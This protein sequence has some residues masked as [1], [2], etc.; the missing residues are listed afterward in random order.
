MKTFASIFAAMMLGLL[1]LADTQAQDFGSAAFFLNPGN[2]CRDLDDQQLL[3]GWAT[4]KLEDSFDLDVAP[5]FESVKPPGGSSR[6]HLQAEQA[7]TTPDQEGSRRLQVCQ[8]DYCMM[9]PTVCAIAGTHKQQ[10]E[11]STK[12]PF[13]CR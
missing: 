1:L 7:A 2:P 12:P 13:P 3:I 9:N 8:L 5:V 11:S 4:Q 10:D 6:R